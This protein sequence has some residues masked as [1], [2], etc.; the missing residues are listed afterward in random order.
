VA[1]HADVAQAQVEAQEKQ[2]V[3]KVIPNFYSSYIWNAAPMTPKQ[4]FGL[5]LRSTT[6]PV[7]FAVTAGVAGVEQWHNTFPGYGGG[8]DGYLK[9][10]GAT[11]ADN[12]I[13][14]MIGSAALPSLLH[15]DPRYF[16][17]GNG[18]IKSRAWYAVSQAFVCRGDD[19]GTEPN[20]SHIVGVFA[21]AGISNL[22]RAPA[23]RSASLTVR[24]SFIILGGSAATNLVR[25]FLLRKITSN[26]PDFAQGKP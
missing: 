23:D 21:A 16:Y 26:V 14:R 12:M 10:Y 18:S 1:T 20:Y 11:Y 17:R 4:K 15:Q 8:T 3:F 24:N 9:R 13:G 6:D 25:E 19:G 22:Y 7:A 5:A 2:R